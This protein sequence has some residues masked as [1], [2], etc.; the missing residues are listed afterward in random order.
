MTVGGVVG[1]YIG[2]D[3]DVCRM[4]RCNHGIKVRK[5]SQPWVNVA[6]VIH[7][8]PAIGQRRGIKRGEPDRV[9]AQLLEIAH[10]RC[11]ARQIA[12]SVARG[13]GKAAWVDLV[14]GRLAPPMGIGRG[15]RNMLIHYVMVPLMTP[16][17]TQRWA[18]T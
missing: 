11:H 1:H 7:V 15:F 12:Q 10:A 16:E 6:V 9:D 17:I 8:V 14:D 2:D 13:I 3:P 18:N 4:S 5:G